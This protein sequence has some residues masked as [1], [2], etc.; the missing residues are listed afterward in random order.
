MREMRDEGDEGDEGDEEKIITQ[1]SSRAERPATANSTH[2]SLLSTPHSALTTRY[3][4][5]KSKLCQEHRK[6]IILLI[7]PLL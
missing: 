5:N 1:H 2:H 3:Q 4:N 6:T 7:N